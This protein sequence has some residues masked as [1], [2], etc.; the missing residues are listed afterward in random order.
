MFLRLCFFFLRDFAWLAVEG[1]SMRNCSGSY[2]RSREREGGGR[3]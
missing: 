2:E 3:I 1:G